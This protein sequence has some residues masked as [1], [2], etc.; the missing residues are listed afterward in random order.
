MKQGEPQSLLVVGSVAFDDIEMP[1]GQRRKR[2]LGGSATHFAMAASPMARTRLVAVVGKDFTANDLHTLTSHNIDVTG[3]EQDK[4][5]MTFHWSGRYAENLDSRKSLETNLNVFE[6]FRPVL[7]DGWERSS[8]VFLGNID[9]TLQLDVLQQMRDPV[10]VAMDTM[11]HWINGARRDDVLNVIS[12]VQVLFVSKEEGRAITGKRRIVEIGPALIQYGPKLVVV[13]DAEH[14]AHLFSR[15]EKEIDHFFTAAYP[16]ENVIDPTG[17]GDSFAG[18][19]LGYLARNAEQMSPGTLRRAMH[20]GSI[21][22]SFCVEGF[23]IERTMHVTL[24]QIEERHRSFLK[25]TSIN[26]D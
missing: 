21:M 3:L 9:P 19:F 16:L 7:P 25:H 12:K 13:K 24:R 8:I 5:G 14:G 11:D 2:L 15:M 6:K 20:I 23:G 18:G 4:S 1:D 26:I 22:A 17:A 10:L